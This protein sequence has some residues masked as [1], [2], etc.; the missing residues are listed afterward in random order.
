MRQGCLPAARLCLAWLGL[1]FALL[2]PLVLA[3][4]PGH[5]AREV[6]VGVLAFRGAEQAVQRWR[7]LM[8]YL[9]SRVPGHRFRL[10]PVYLSSAES[11]LA[12]GR[13]DFLITNPGHYVALAERVPLAPLATLKRPHPRN[14]WLVRFG[15]VVFVRAAREDLE[16]L[17]DLRGRALAAVSPDAFGG[18][19]VAWEVFHDRGLDP[20]DDM[21]MRFAG[22]PQDH[23]VELVRLGKADAGI[24]RTGL[25]ESLAAEGKIKLSDFR[26]L[27]RQFHAGFPYL[28]ST[29]LYPEWPFAARGGVDLALVE[30]VAL[31]LLATGSG[32]AMARQGLDFAWTAPRSYDG[33]RAL[34]GHFQ[35]AR[36]QPPAAW[37]Y[38]LLGLAVA[39]ALAAIIWWTRQRQAAP[40][41]VSLPAHEEEDVPRE[42]AEAFRHLTPRELEVL[43]CLCEGLSTKEIA[44]RLDI[45]PKTVDYHRGNLLK[46]TGLQSTTRLVSMATRLHLFGHPGENPGQNREN[47]R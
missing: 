32:D 14:G 15:S 46:K 44:R 10:V 18:F 8:R 16:T 2:G 38:V 4:Q 42:L 30:R 17:N 24:V 41:I 13:I 26:V 7:P 21:A 9:E 22:F 37:P 47:S 28:V 6:R 34:I 40:V 39:L 45:A 20:L 3:T 19:L 12:N 43:A 36:R 31:A 23:I 27:N 5:A 1:V 29:R 33:V 11:L 25:L 35:Q